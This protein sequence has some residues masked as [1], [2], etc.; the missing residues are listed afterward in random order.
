MKV[1]GME[2]DRP[3]IW[4]YLETK[5]VP[6]I[7]KLLSEVQDSSAALQQSGHLNRLKATTFKE[8]GTYNYL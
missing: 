4:D 1:A 6:F 3:I 2:E 7:V 5:I 8:G